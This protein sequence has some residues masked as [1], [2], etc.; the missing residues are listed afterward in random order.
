MS[1]N[2]ATHLRSNQMEQAVPGQ[3]KNNAGGFVF[4]ITPAKQLER[5]LILGSDSNTYYQTA[6]ELTRDNA[7]VVEACWNGDAQSTLDMILDVSLNG[8]APKND[9]AIFAMAL[10]TINADV[11]V[12][13]MV[14]A[15]ILKVCRTATHIFQ[16]ID[17]CQTLGKGWG[18]GLKNVVKRYY[19]NTDPNRLGYQM[20]KY[21]NRHNFTHQRLIQTS[22]P[23][24][25]DDV[26]GYDKNVMFKWAVGKEISE[27][28]KEKLPVIIQDF[29]RVQTSEKIDLD[30]VSKLPWEAL[31]TEWLNDARTWVSLLPGMGTTALIRNLAKMS[32]VGV[33]AAMSNEEREVCS[34]LREKALIEK[35]RIHPMNVLFALK[36]YSSGHGFR[37]ANSWKANNEVVAA[38]EDTFELAFQ[39]VPKGN[40]RTY[41]AIDCSGSMTIP[42]ANSNVSVREAAAAMA[43]ITIRS[44]PQVVIRGFTSGGGQRYVHTRCDGMQDL[45]ITRKDSLLGATLK[46]NLANWGGTD[47]SLP[48]IDAMNNKIPVDQFVIYTDND[49]WAGKVHP[50]QALKDYRKAMGI[51]AK[52]VVVGMT[53]HGHSIAD[54]RD[55]KMLDVVGFDT[56]APALIAGF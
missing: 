35:D 50:Y 11:K 39:N 49:T 45:G 52:L 48:M 5:F 34:R 18:R 28:E 41:V 56:S 23:N 55:D 9:P 36:T 10:G 54:P 38:L 43:M 46:C 16:F 12:R 47:C 53:S 31:P 8:K 29:L 20:V 32:T 40:K 24:P 42:I 15:N 13:Q 30:L 26:N 27:S 6:R 33:L 3:V 21:R 37:G 1:K 22:H 17:L 51:D 7:G 19:E 14:Y 44:E 25:L 4:K 2:Y